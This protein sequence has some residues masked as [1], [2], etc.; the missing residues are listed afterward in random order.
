MRDVRALVPRP[1]ELQVTMDNRICT[2][3]MA[4]TLTACR[5]GSPPEWTPKRFQAA[6][7][8]T[9][10]SESAASSAGPLEPRND[11]PS[12][13]AQLPVAT[14]GASTS[15]A[16][17]PCD[18]CS[19]DCLDQADKLKTKE[20]GVAKKLAALGCDIG[21]CGHLSQLMM[22][23]CREYGLPPADPVECQN[24]CVG[25]CNGEDPRGPAWDACM[26]DCEA[27]H[28]CSGD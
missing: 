28:G 11:P 21:K 20:P 3:L 27:S 24:Q 1:Q 13:A 12:T 25:E 22:S 2:P 15:S 23:R 26:K 10:G 5:L 7:S 9:V 8:S 4:L 18:P 14:H 17:P 6:R 19:F 16:E